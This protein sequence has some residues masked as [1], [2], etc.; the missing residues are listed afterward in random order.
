MDVRTLTA[1]SLAKRQL[2]GETGFVKVPQET[3]QEGAG[4]SALRL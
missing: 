4:R 1:T 2:W 3:S